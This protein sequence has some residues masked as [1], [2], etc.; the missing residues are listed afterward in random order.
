M[1]PARASST[2]RTSAAPAT[3]SAFGVA[4]DASG[5]AY[6]TGRTSLDRLPGGTATPF[7]GTSG[8]GT[9]AFVVKLNPRPPARRR[10]STRPTSAAAA[11]TE[12]MASSWTRRAMPRWSGAPTRPTSRWEPA[13]HFRAPTG[14]VST[15]SSRGSVA[16]GSTLL[17]ATYLG[18][19]GEDRGFGIARDSSN[20]VYITG[21]DQ[22][23]QFPDHRRRLRHG[24]RKRRQL[25]LR[26]PRTPTWRS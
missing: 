21:Q 9:D 20:N 7:Q 3:T 25:Q 26:V 17:Y 16:A 13:P 22:L 12:A 2:P 10:S 8:G 6:V 14:A 19:S 4:L 24:L 15:P 5:N 23:D 1:R 11:T 18:G